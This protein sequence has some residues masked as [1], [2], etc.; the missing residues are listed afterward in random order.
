MMNIS[1]DLLYRQ[2][3]ILSLHYAISECDE[4]TLI[5]IIEEGQTHD[6]YYCDYIVQDVRFVQ[7]QTTEEIMITW[8]AWTDSRRMH[9]RTYL[10]SL[11][12]SF[13]VQRVDLLKTTCIGREKNI[14]PTA[15]QFAN[16]LLLAQINLVEGRVSLS[17]HDIETLDVTLPITLIQES[18]SYDFY[19]RP[20]GCLEKFSVTKVDANE[21]AIMFYDEFDER[22][23]YTCRM[24]S[25]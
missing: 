10:L 9:S 3:R 18:I 21:A 22:C 20:E 25:I 13:A 24:N 23:I 17:L 6:L 4:H 15:V 19:H 5:S 8:L 2:G 14:F 16:L 11:S 1:H 7:N 12:A